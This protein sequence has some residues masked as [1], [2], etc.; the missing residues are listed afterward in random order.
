MTPQESDKD[1]I[2]L[3]DRVF[4]SIPDFKEWIENTQL[5]QVLKQESNNPS[6]F[7]VPTIRSEQ[8]SIGLNSGIKVD[9]AY[10]LP[11]EVIFEFFLNSPYYNNKFNFNNIINLL[12][13][14]NKD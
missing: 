14:E 3:K 6:N 10:D 5:F 4:S 11:I 7:G 9:T 2:V 13:Y 12:G 1:P 8:I